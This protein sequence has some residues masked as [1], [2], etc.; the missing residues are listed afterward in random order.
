MK[1]LIPM[2]LVFVLAGEAIMS[3]LIVMGYDDR[4]IRLGYGLG[5]LLGMSWAGI[6]NYLLQTHKE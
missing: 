6:L 4:T 1:Y 5:I 3:G 2:F